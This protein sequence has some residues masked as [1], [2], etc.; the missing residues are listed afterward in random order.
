[1]L[2]RRQALKISGLSAAAYVLPFQ[3]SHAVESQPKPSDFKLCLNMSTLRGHKL[4]FIKELETASRAGFRSAE[5]WIDSLQQYLN[6]GGTIKEAKNRM[7]SLG[8]TAENTI[9]FAKWIVDDDE[10]RKQ[11]IEQLKKEMD[12]IAQIG[13]K[14]IAAPPA[15]ATNTAGLDLR[16]AAERYRVI[17]ELGDQTG[18]VPHLE[19]WG[20]SKNLNRASEVVFVAMESGHPSARILLDVYHLYKGGS[21]V[22]TLPLI[23]KPAMELIHINDYPS[24]N[25]ETITDAD[26][27]HPGDGIAPIKQI[28]KNIKRTDTPLI[29]SEE[30]FNK[31]YYTQDPLEVAKTAFAK[32]KKVIEGV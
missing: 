4:G 31:N 24:I 28:L 5:I 2:N 13:C 27:V 14:R 9:G 23:A 19:L 29:L 8:I 18:V 32:I 12:I 10:V 21:P 11:G 30:V 22:D 6:S 1:M 15:G 20:F 17:L 7:N 16:K 3:G 25:R 26:R